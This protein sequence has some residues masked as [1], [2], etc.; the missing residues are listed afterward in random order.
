MT[1]RIERRTRNGKDQP[2]EI[3]GITRGDQG[4]GAIGRLDDGHAEA[5]AGNQP[6]APREIAC[7]WL[8]AKG[9][10]ADRQTPARRDLVKQADVFG[11]VGPIQA[12]G[13]RGDRAAFEACAM[14]SGIDTARETRGDD[15]AGATGIAGNHRRELGAADRRVARADNAER[16][17]GCC[18]EIALHREERGS[19]VDL[20]KR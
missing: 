11:R 6:V 17:A 4:A 1:P 13:K 2:A 7:T 16:R 12:A 15:I 5:D 19:A 3:G 18:F 20:P 14:G 10:F 9:H 8:P